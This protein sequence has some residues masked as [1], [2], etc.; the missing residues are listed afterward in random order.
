MVL[1]HMHAAQQSKKE[2]TSGAIKNEN[3][4]YLFTVS[5][6]YLLPVS[7]YG[8]RGRN[9]RAYLLRIRTS[10]GRKGGVVVVV[11]ESLGLPDDGVGDL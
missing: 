7:N 6:A 2:K 10:E 1:L 3:T 4:T 8:V 5:L 11:R 9:P